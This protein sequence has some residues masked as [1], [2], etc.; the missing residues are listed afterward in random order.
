MA[1]RFIFLSIDRT[2]ASGGVAV[3]YDC[4]RLA[5]EAGHD[6][7]VMHGVPGFVHVNGRADVPVTW[8]NRI[9]R[10]RAALGKPLSIRQKLRRFRQMH[11]PV[12][13]DL[14]LRP[15]DVVVVPE[16]FLLP[17][18]LAFPD[19][20]KVLFSQNPFLH[21][22]AAETARLA[23]CDPV[24]PFVLHV[25]IARVC[26]EAISLLGATDMAQFPVSPRLQAFE[27]REE[28]R[29]VV[30]Y[31]PRKRPEQARVFADALRRRGK[32]HGFDLL[33]IDDMTPDEVS[34]AVGSS[35]VFASLMAEE[36]LGFPAAE[37]MAAGCVTVGYTG[38]GTREY[39][40]ETTGVPVP[41]GD[42]NGLVEAVEQAIA[43]HRADPSHFDEMRRRASRRIH[44][45]YSE[46]RFREGLLAMLDRV[47]G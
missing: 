46:D 25:G 21:L 20:R 17:S 10:A 35:R 31:M 38:I 16:L 3:L 29:D 24:A 23:G 19:H 43:H 4:V 45:R 30:A 32:L 13:G 41:E 7:V 27:Y 11:A 42:L 8:S 44:D 15:D 2:Q 40:D 14:D 36:A 1:P 47:A 5:R 39:F 22:R 33:E 28:K 37:A 6:A 18:L 26:M 34:E 12:R 9:D